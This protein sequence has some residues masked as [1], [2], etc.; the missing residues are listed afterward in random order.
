MAKNP[1]GEGMT[2]L[3]AWWARR[4]R[5]GQWTLGLL[6]VWIVAL[7]ADTMGLADGFNSAVIALSSM[8]LVPLLM[9]VGLRWFFARFLWK[10]RN[11]LILTYL[12]MGLAPVVLVASLA[13]IA[14]YM[15]AGQF[16]TDT[17]LSLL[18][19][20]TNQIRDQAYAV[21][22]FGPAWSPAR[23][24]AQNPAQSPAP[25]AAHPTGGR[26]KAAAGAAGAEVVSASAAGVDRAGVELGIAAAELRGKAWVPVMTP[27][28]EDGALAG[29][30]MGE[31]APAWLKPGFQ[32]IVSVKYKLY[33]C[34]EVSAPRAGRAVVVLASKP[35][36]PS[37]LKRMANGF[38]RITLT[39]A[40][41]RTTAVPVRIDSNG[42]DIDM[43]TVDKEGQHEF[44]T[45][46]GGELGQKRHFF[47]LPVV[48]S[49]PIT[50]TDWESGNAI[51]SMILVMSRPTQLYARLF[52]TAAGSGQVVR[53]VLFGI[54]VFFALLELVALLMAVSLSRTIT[55]SV[56]ELYTGT[57]EIDAGHLEHRIP[58]KRKDQ[59]AALASSF[60]GMAASVSEL[61]VQQREKE[62]L[63]NE[64]AIAQEVQATLFPVSPASVKGFEVHGVC[65]PARTI[66]GD[67][68]DFIFRLGGG[69][70]LTLALGDI[71]GKGISAALLMSSLHS[72]DR[73]FL[74][75][76]GVE[77]DAVPSPAKLLKLLNEH[78]FLSTQSARYATLFLAS[79]DAAT[80]RLTYAN[81][82]HLPPLVIAKDGSV[83][84]LDCGGSVVGLMEGMEY[85][86]ATVQL[87]PGDLLVAFTDGL[88]EP[89]KSGEDFG[90]QRLLDYVRDHR[91]EPLTILAANTLQVVKSWIGE[92][93][94]PDDMTIV[95]A[96][97]L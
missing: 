74:V 19:Q 28:G 37:E 4:S 80:R 45:V 33:L 79:Y 76:L 32:G 3:R 63:L 18:D 91:N 35:L 75:G 84:R 31:P 58:V 17:A 60:N 26:D 24:P 5:V 93:E 62:R 41:T 59:L 6:A 72:A 61:L 88:T 69:G 13:G 15:F 68:F 92:Q 7:T 70:G 14:G 2:R 86:E 48:F 83:R 46:T 56:A 71:S 50:A 25:T 8:A 44:D 95:M 23:N 16:A 39:K 10:V 55:R 85:E 29:A 49:A 90:E 96:R 94:Q 38:G 57:K 42:T 30:L 81:G 52:S 65:I 20:R 87:E 54:A 43:A 64:L 12:L 27:S 89:E 9:I 47:D 82:G 77:D 21:A 66:G 1:E 73:A 36:T 22:L 51:P 78:L 97:Q 34:A 53:A 67:Y 11:R 40:F